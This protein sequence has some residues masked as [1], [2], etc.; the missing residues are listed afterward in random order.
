MWPRGKA[1]ALS[2]WPA[3]W[4]FACVLPGGWRKGLCPL[5]CSFM[6]VSKQLQRCF[7]PESPKCL[8]LPLAP[9][10]TAVVPCTAYCC[11]P[12]SCPSCS[13]LGLLLCRVS[14]EPVAMQKS[15][16]IPWGAKKTLARAGRWRWGGNPWCLAV[17]QLLGQK[18]I[19][20]LGL[21]L[22]VAESP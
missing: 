10:A 12:H 3:P 7:G 1:F 14:P 8:Q 16:A 19:C 13:L 22:G 5:G 6:L 17:I 4:S 21:C 9:V 18:Q 20:C 11:S 2:P 15:Q